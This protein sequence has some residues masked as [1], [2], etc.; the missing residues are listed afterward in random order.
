MPYARKDLIKWMPGGY[1]HLYNRGARRLTI[2]PDEASY[3]SVLKMIKEYCQKYHFTL[4]AYCLMPNHYHFLV[5]QGGEVE[6]G[7]LPRRVFN[8]YSHAYNL[9]HGNSGTLFESRFKATHV[10][11]D[12]YLHTLCR[13]IHANPVKD[14]IVG[15]IEEWPFSNYLDW[16]GERRGELLDRDFVEQHFRGA[17][18]YR[19]EMTE[20]IGAKRYLDRRF[21]DLL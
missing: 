9:R 6:A 5:R 14:G 19:Q 13:Y 7:Q 16:I 11:S 12:E 2:F 18:T 8:R 3:L 20:Y 1:Y 21:D 15:R 10:D 17:A 4:I